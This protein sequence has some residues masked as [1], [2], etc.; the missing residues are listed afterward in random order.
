MWCS[1]CQ[2]D[3]PA[4]RG[5]SDRLACA[6][7][8]RKLDGPADCGISLEQFDRPA[9]TASQVQSAREL[10][11]SSHADSE[12][13]RLERLLRPT[14]PFAV[15][16]R[17]FLE[18]L[19]PRDGM[20]FDDAQAAERSATIELRRPTATRRSPESGGVGLLWAL[21]I[22]AFAAG[23]IALG[24]SLSLENAAAW[25]FGVAAVVGGEGLLVI[26][27]AMLVARLW[28]RSGRLSQQIE[29]VDWRVA[30]L[31]GQRRDAA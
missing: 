6:R 17:G 13:K 14:V 25:R 3:V 29:G 30:E 18:H 4:A 24:L 9:A 19:M 21:G 5:A 22:A 26:G 23:V 31:Q 28:Q 12:L 2:Q 20:T 27:L 15:K 16:Q 10:L 1:H 8:R 7:C 11:S